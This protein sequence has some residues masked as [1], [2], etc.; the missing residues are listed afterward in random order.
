MALSTTERAS[1]RRYLGWTTAFRQITPGLEN[2]MERIAEVPEDEAEVRSLLAQLTDIETRL[3]TGARDRL[4]ASQVGSITLN[5]AEVYQ[6]RAEGRRF[7]RQIAALL[8]VEILQNAF[9]GGVAGGEVM[10]G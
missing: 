10:H 9:G 5:A 2:A 1:I 6:L 8:D 3:N 7:V 4:Q